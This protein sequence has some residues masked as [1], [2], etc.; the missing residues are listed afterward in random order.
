MAKYDPKDYNGYTPADDSTDPAT[1]ESYEGDAK[2]VKDAID[3]LQS[4]ID[5]EGC[6]K[7]GLENAWGDFYRVVSILT[8]K[9]A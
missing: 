7:S 3:K 5:N 2:I 9:G 1:P 6:D 8:K 4:K